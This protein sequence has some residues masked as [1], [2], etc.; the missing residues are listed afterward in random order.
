MRTVRERPL[1]KERCKWEDDIKA[2]VRDIG[3]EDL[4][5]I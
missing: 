1:W 4:K 5:G 2:D 3:F